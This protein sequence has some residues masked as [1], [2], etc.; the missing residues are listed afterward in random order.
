MR[1]PI[2]LLGALAGCAAPVPAPEDLN[3]VKAE[4]YLATLNALARENPA[5]LLYVRNGSK[6]QILPFLILARLEHHSEELSVVW[7]RMEEERD[8]WQAFSAAMCAWR[9]EVRPGGQPIE[10]L[11]SPVALSQDRQRAAV[12]CAFRGGYVMA[13]LERRGGSFEARME[14]NPVIE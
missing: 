8:D 3:A 12:V 13:L 2:L 14:P 11:L 10:Y 1:F 4:I 7:M 9:P 5:D 6:R